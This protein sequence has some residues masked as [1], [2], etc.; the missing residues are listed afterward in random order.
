MVVGTKSLANLLHGQSALALKLALIDRPATI[1]TSVPFLPHPPRENGG[2]R[3][4]GAKAKEPQPT[5]ETA[6]PAGDGPM[7]T[8]PLPVD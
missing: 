1:V 4:D 6:A 7:P 8:P 2:A 3:R 5:V